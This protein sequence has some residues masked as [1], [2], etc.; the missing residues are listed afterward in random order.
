M[1]DRLVGMFAFA[2]WDERREQL[3]AGARPAR[4][5]SRCTGSTTASRFAFASEIKALLPLLPRRE[6]DPVAL[7]HYL[8]FVAV[9][10]PRTLF[11]GVSQ[12]GARRRTLLVE[13]D[14]PRRAASATGTR[15]RN[16]A[17]FDGADRRLGGRA[18]ASGSSARSTA[19]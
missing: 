9:P 5:S 3:F 2:I 15:S 16:R 19:G 17:E 13:R 8:T 1:V 18:A 14:G 10:P 11:A 4:A 6:I 7:A 12:A